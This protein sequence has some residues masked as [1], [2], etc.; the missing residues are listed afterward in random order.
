MH[1]SHSLIF[2]NVRLL[3]FLGRIGWRS[4][5]A[6]LHHLYLC[7][8]T[9]IVM[10]SVNH[11]HFVSMHQIR[12][13]KEVLFDTGIRSHVMECTCNTDNKPY[14]TSWQTQQFCGGKSL[15]FTM[16]LSFIAGSW[17]QFY[18]CHCLQQLHSLV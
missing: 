13:M 11:F 18:V 17:L 6:W 7:W 1:Y 2:S 15:L 16:S 4:F 3:Y 14:L 5:K 10:W 8:N 12:L 9:E